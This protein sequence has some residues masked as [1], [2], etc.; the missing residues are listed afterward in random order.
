MISS[1]N[2]FGLRHHNDW[3]DDSRKSYRPPHWPPPSDWVV[4]EDREGKVFHIGQIRFGIFHLGQE[5]LSA[6]VLVTTLI[7]LR[8]MKL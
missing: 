5:K 2:I 7:T 8:K 3:L 1:L 4:S 6:L